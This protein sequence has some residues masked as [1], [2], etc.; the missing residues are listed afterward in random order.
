MLRSWSRLPVGQVSSTPALTLLERWDYTLHRE[1]S[2]G[3]DTMYLILFNKV[4]AT[5]TNMRV[6]TGLLLIRLLW[7]RQIGAAG[8]VFVLL[9]MHLSVGRTFYLGPG[10]FP[11]C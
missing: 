7:V 10:I 4:S 6:E 5:L 11:L 9:S 1:S 8:A 3:S 2:N